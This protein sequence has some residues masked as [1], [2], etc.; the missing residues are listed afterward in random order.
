MKKQTTKPSDWFMPEIERRTKEL[1]KIMKM[2]KQTTENYYKGISMDVTNKEIADYYKGKKIDD[3]DKLL[4][5]TARNNFHAGRLSAK[6][7]NMKEIEFAIRRTKEKTLDDV[8]KIIDKLEW[9]GKVRLKA[10]IAK[11]KESK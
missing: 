1:D 4:L 9:I 3:A 5:D 10:E 6:E 11:L 8:E 2:K 7:E